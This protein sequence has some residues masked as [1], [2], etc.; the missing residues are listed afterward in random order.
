MATRATIKIEGVN[1]AK[2]YKHW[3]GYPEGILPWLIKFHKMFLTKRGYDPTYQFAQL[4]RSSVD[5]EGEF[6]LDNS[7][8]TGYGIIEYDASA[9]EEYEYILKKNGCI[10]VKENIYN[11]KTDELEWKEIKSYNVLISKD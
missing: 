9:G 2:L 5:Y 7:R 3:D 11:E 10:I 1:F 8:I 6:D 4:L